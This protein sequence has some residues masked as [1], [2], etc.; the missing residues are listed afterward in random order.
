MRFSGR[1]LV[2]DLAVR[3]NAV[4]ALRQ[5]VVSTVIIDNVA[6]IIRLCPVL[7]TSAASS[8]GGACVDAVSIVR[9]LASDLGEGNGGHGE[10]DQSACVF[11]LEKEEKEKKEKKM[12]SVKREQART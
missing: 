1:D 9:T 7:Q 2:N 5:E 8:S 10:E 3:E 12:P 6:E 4:G 11:H